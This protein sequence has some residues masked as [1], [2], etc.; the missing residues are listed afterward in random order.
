MEVTTHDT[1]QRSLLRSMLL[2]EGQVITS[3][4]AKESNRSIAWICLI[5]A[6]SSRQ[7]I[8]IVK[9]FEQVA[10]EEGDTQAKS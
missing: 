4:Q 8:A 6:E 5:Q 2:R 9:W 10:L 7:S 3:T 1:C